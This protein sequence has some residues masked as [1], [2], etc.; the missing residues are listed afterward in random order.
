MCITYYVLLSGI[1]IQ[2]DL[3]IWSIILYEPPLC[4]G[5]H[6]CLRYVLWSTSVWEDLSMLRSYCSS[7]EWSVVLV[8]EL[9]PRCLHL[10]CHSDLPMAIIRSSY[11]EWFNPWYYFIIFL[12][13]ILIYCRKAR[14]SFWTSSATLCRINS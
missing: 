11:F 6:S 5:P 1:W 12:F 13:L 14:L 9:L 3:L 2:Y 10:I 8:L 7:I 4:V